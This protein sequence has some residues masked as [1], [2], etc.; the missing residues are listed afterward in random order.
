MNIA[1]Q[2]ILPALVILLLAGSLLGIALGLALLWRSDA[3][4][5]F[6]EIMN[7]WVSTR[8]AFRPL[9][10][11]REIKPRG[12]AGRWLVGALIVLGA[13]AAIVLIGGIDPARLAAALKV[14]PRYSVAGLGLEAARWFLALGA[15][16]AVVTGVMLVFFPRAWEAVEA[17]ADRW[18]STRELEASGDRLHL[19][20]DRVVQAFP[21]ASGAAILALSLVAAIASAVRLL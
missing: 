11:P 6:M 10:V 1:M 16:V 9:E 12:S 5:R 2:I 20:L 3:A 7:R 8:R 13:Y 17:R 4:L 18:Y 21:R 14:D 15:L 19:S